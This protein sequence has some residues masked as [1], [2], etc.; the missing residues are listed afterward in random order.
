MVALPAALRDVSCL[1]T[2]SVPSGAAVGGTG[3][4]T[5]I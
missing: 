2:V 3:P 5:D 1:R 4:G